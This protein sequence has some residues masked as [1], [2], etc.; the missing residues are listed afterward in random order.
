MILDGPLNAQRATSMRLAAD[1]SGFISLSILEVPSVATFKLSAPNFAIKKSTKLVPASS[2]MCSDSDRISLA[3]SIGARF[4]DKIASAAAFS[5]LLILNIWLTFAS[6]V[7]NKI[8]SRSELKATICWN[9]AFNAIYPRWS[10]SPSFTRSGRSRSCS[11]SSSRRTFI[12]DLTLPVKAEWLFLRVSD[13]TLI[14][15]TVLRQARQKT[16][17]LWSISC[18]S[19]DRNV[20]NGIHLSSPRLL[21]TKL[22][23]CSAKTCSSSIQVSMHRRTMS[24]NTRNCESWCSGELSL[25]VNWRILLNP[26]SFTK[27]STRLWLFN[28]ECNTINTPCIDSASIGLVAKQVSII[29]ITRLKTSRRVVSGSSCTWLSKAAELFCTA[30]GLDTVSS[31]FVSHNSPSFSSFSSQPAVMIEGVDRTDAF[32]D[33]VTIVSAA[34]AAVDSMGLACAGNESSSKRISMAGEIHRGQCCTRSWITFFVEDN[35]RSTNSQTQSRE[36][37]PALTKP[38]RMTGWTI[39]WWSRYMS[40]CR[41]ERTAGLYPLPTSWAWSFSS[42]TI[43]SYIAVKERSLAGELPCFNLNRRSTMKGIN[44]WVSRASH[45]HTCS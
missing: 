10:G 30:S 5:A 4:R 35:T 38:L 8:N 2:C 28:K 24:V 7:V 26:P 42:A 20:L 31:V 6:S 40:P 3:A 21:L 39:I 13:S 37:A 14:I 45:W 36:R 41:L 1:I 17:G 27:I 15:F 11:S 29:E 18:A 34:A 12:S 22:R 16:S 19:A 25:L 32:L 43:C 23:I 9:S 33:G 44:M